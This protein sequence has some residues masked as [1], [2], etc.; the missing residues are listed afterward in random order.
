MKGLRLEAA[1]MAVL[2][3]LIA[4]SVVVLLPVMTA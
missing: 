2:T 3:A 1:A 4:W